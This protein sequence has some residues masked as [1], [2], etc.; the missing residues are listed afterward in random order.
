MSRKCDNR[1]CGTRKCYYF[2]VDARGHNPILGFC[3][4]ACIADALQH[5]RKEVMEVE[6]R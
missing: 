5:H 1:A 3:S 2:I 4:L 6:A